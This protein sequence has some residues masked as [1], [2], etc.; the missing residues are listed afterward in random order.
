LARDT[1][2]HDEKDNQENGKTLLRRTR[3]CQLP[4][5]SFYIGCFGAA[6]PDRQATTEL[7]RMPR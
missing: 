1:S 7:T 6:S 5:G 3:R 2:E 4:V